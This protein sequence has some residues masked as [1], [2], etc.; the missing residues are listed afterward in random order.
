MNYIKRLTYDTNCN[1][2][3]KQMQALSKSTKNEKLLKIIINKYYNNAFYVLE[4]T[5]NCCFIEKK[6][7]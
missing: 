3:H 4:Y 5:I 1:I 2:Y 7:N 6:I